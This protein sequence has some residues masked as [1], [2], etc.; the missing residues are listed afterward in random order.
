MKDSC[1]PAEKKASWAL[2]SVAVEDCM[3][4]GTRQLSVR[5]AVLKLCVSGGVE[6]VVTVR[7]EKAAAVVCGELGTLSC[8]RDGVLPSTSRLKRNDSSR[9][10]RR[11]EVS[12]VV[13][14]T[15]TSP[16]FAS[17]S[18]TVPLIVFAA[19]DDPQTVSS[20][21]ATITSRVVT[22]MLSFIWRER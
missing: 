19:A 8:V 17:L 15:L 1:V 18:C 6:E 7:V 3:L 11:G 20:R 14:K 5:A 16:G 22:F 2:R 13:E 9:T 4:N 10:A 21:M 12:D